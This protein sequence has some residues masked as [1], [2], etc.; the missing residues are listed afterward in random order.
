ME[1]ILTIDNKQV[2]FKSSGA[3]LLRYKAQ[4]GR[5]AMADIAK[6]EGIVDKKGNVKDLGQLDLEV[7]YDMIWT[8]AKTADRSIPPPFEWLD[9]F[10]EFPIIDI[11]PELM[12]LILSNFT[13][14]VTSKKK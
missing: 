14:S 6:L 10:R 9:S 3:F 11:L 1:K 12:E 5:D 7:F 4:T 8:L 13:T 2:P